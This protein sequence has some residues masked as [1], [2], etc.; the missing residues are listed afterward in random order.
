MQCPPFFN[1][2]FMSQHY[3][4]DDDTRRLDLPQPSE[5]KAITLIVA[6]AIVTALAGCVLIFGDWQP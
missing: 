6:A 4:Q 5:W 1:H 2:R 3:D